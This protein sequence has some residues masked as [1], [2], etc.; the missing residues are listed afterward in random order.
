MGKLT[1]LGFKELS[2]IA[3]LS[4]CFCIAIATTSH[5]VIAKTPD[6]VKRSDQFAELLS[7]AISSED[8]Q[9]KFVLGDRLL[10][11][12]PAFR[13]C[14]QQNLQKVVRTLEQKLAQEKNAALR[15]D[16]D[17]LLK[18][19]QRSLRAY[20]LDEK[21]QLP[22]VHLS[23]AILNTLKLTLNEAKLSSSK[24]DAIA[25][26]LN[27]FAG[28]QSG[29]AS[30]ASSLQQAMYEQLQ[31]TEIVLPSREQLVT[32]LKSNASKVYAIESFLKQ[33]HIPDYE[34]AYA[35]LKTQL[36]NY[37][38]FIRHEVLP[39]TKQNFRLPR[40]LYALKLEEQGITAP[41]EE[42]MEQAHTAF[43]QI[44]QEMEAIAPKIA[45]RKQLNTNN[46]R[47]VIKALQ[48]ER[49]SAKD[50]L[51]LY[52]RRA[53]ELESIIQRE[54]LVTLPKHDLNIRLS[55]KKE[56]QNFPVPLYN[57]DSATF[58]LPVAQNPKKAI[59]YND[60]TN[61][62]MSWTL[63]VHEGRPGHDL[64]FATMRDQTLSQARS[65]FAANGT[66]IEGWATYAESMM[67]PYMPIEGRFM[68]LQFELLRA[69]RA[70]LEPELQLGKITVEEA[71]QTITQDAGFSKFFAQQEVKRYTKTMQGQAPTYFY[72]SQQFW[73]LRSQIEQTLGKQFTPQKFH[74]FV[75]S[76]GFLMPKVLQQLFLSQII[77]IN[78]Y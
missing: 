4:C 16:L 47:D 73:Q 72:G 23:E 35:Q 22:Y 49:L 70:F 28:F 31:K 76:Q 68:S 65:S 69:A 40:E 1:K 6:W 24:Q 25:L 33:Q 7:E 27:Q 55:T 46:Y 38:T 71:L 50:T 10:E 17:I 14:R 30:L 45:Q 75:L 9:E 18:A 36:F 63:T 42:I 48:Q 2:A 43:S 60:F 29:K 77:N 13:A 53:K 74:D 61:P 58:V 26:K 64:Q 59:L 54:H 44:Q 56:Y 62:A 51:K 57:P 15:L 3:I 21:Y 67:Q 11:V 32:D 8:C 34:T 5:P 52:Q 66:N 20:K 78:R 39:K 41:I 19:G 12:N 37:E